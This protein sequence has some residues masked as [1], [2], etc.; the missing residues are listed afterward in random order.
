MAR[1]IRAF[2]D[3]RRREPKK[4]LAMGESSRPK[5]DHGLRV[6]IAGGGVAG[7]ETLLALRALAGELIELELLAPE[8]EFWYR[9]LAVAEPFGLARAEHFD[10]ATIADSVGA[11]FT[12]DELTSVDAAEHVARTAHGA[13]TRYDA[14]VIACGALPRP[15]LPGALTFRGPADSDAFSELLT[16]AEQGIVSSIAFAAPSAG[17]WPLPLYELALLTAVRVAAYDHQVRL[18]LVTTEPSP[19]A[20][21]GPAASDAVRALLAEHAIELHSGSYPARYDSGRLE[22][23]PATTIAVDRVVALPRLEGPRILG[24]PQDDNGFVAT[25]RQGRVRGL[26]DVYAAGD[27]TQFPVKQ[28]GL[29]AQQADAVAE[30]IASQAGA[31]ITPH[32]FRPVL[33]GLLLTGTAP[34]YLRNELRGGLGETSTVA[35]DI[36]WW[37]PGKIVGRYLAPYLADAVGLDLAQRATQAGDVAV[38][39][40]L[41]AAH[42]ADASSTPSRRD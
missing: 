34:R 15:T 31:A 24:L 13:E 32:P 30:A 37:P 33:R 5:R 26:E 12:L 40:D 29:A 9:P 19:L 6:L 2:P 14:L 42:D 20:L 23:V 27:I 25:D 4:S 21:F 22:L 35:T 11:V 10:L 38:T 8:P 1:P 36:L 18:A 41:A 16:E 17:I 28:G 7:L 39:V 3:A